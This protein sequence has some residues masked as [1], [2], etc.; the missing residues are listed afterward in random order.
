[1]GREKKEMIDKAQEGEVSP[2]P[3]WGGVLL[4]RA[5]TLRSVAAVPGCRFVILQRGSNT[6][7]RSLIGLSSSITPPL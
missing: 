1:M 5:T 3:A 2:G 4:F 7:P 6:P